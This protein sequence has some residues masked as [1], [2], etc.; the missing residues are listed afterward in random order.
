MMRTIVTIESS[1]KRWLDRYSERHQQSTAKTIRLA[2]KEF[3]KKTR[4]G[5]YRNVLKQTAGLFKG[6]KDD[7]VRFV[8]K[9][10]GEW[11]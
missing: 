4:E 11:D 1:D 10:R 5:N 6:D 7:S 2:I 8:R 9:L 3:Q